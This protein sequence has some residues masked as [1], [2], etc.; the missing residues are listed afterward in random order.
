MNTDEIRPIVYLGV[1]TGRIDSSRPNRTN[2]PKS[3]A[4]AIA[5]LTA[6]RQAHDAARLE[7]VA[8]ERDA[9]KRD[10]AD[11][12]DGF[13]VL[14]ATVTAM[15]VERGRLLTERDARLNHAALLRQVN[16]DQ[17]AEIVRLRRALGEVQSA[18]TE[19]ARERDAL[20][21]TQAAT[22]RAALLIG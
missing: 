4:D 5:R 11:I 14:C 12:R 13:N 2:A 6:D 3:F 17:A 15:R 19:I 20:R 21:E 18:A 22:V 16:A 10:V 1:Q 9:L 7:A 8:R